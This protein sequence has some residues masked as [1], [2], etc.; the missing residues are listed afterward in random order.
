MCIHVGDRVITKL[1]GL[2]GGAILGGAMGYFANLAVTE[3]STIFSK[4]LGWSLDP[5]VFF[6][7]EKNVIANQLHLG[8]YAMWIGIV[9]GTL[10]GI[11]MQGDTI[12][13]YVGYYLGWSFFDTVQTFFGTLLRILLASVFTVIGVILGNVIFWI[14][15]HIEAFLF[16]ATY[17]SN[18]VNGNKGTDFLTFVIFMVLLLIHAVLGWFHSALEWLHSVSGLSVNT[19]LITVHWAFAMCGGTLGM[20]AISG[21]PDE[22]IECPYCHVKSGKVLSKGGSAIVGNWSAVRSYAGN[23]QCRKCGKSFSHGYDGF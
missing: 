12:R 20:S 11:R 19:L 22:A 4:L 7:C 21:N 23:A 13:F 16:S 8:D 10:A 17:I 9:L 5:S 1:I 15:A 6:C 18:Q 3:T 14:L 2:V